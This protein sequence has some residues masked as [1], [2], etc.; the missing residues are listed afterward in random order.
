MS[1]P[2]LPVNLRDENEMRDY[3]RRLQ[4]WIKYLSEKR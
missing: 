2:A 3:F 1:E 4:E